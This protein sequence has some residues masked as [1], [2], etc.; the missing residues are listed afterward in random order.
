MSTAA[1][2]ISNLGTY[3]WNARVY[4]VLALASQLAAA[5]KNRGSVIRIAYHLRNLNTS[6]SE[7]V[8]I[9]NESM[10]GKRKS[11]PNADPV[12]AQTLRSS[13]DNLEQM[14][15]TLDYIVEGAR[16]AG[17]TNNSLTAG[18]VRGLQKNLDAIA[19]LAD[20]LDLAAQPDAV[21]GIFERARQERER[22]ELIDLAKI[23]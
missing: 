13:A 23:E 3:N 5:V 14:Y 4:N 2:V 16:R 7:F 10:E 11:N 12:T 18:S 8:T 15:R 19:S 22:G 17:L 6:V 20:W 21:N 1:T 9:V